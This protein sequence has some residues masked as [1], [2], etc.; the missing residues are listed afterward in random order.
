[1]SSKSAPHNYSK[2][3]YGN[4]SKRGRKGYLIVTVVLLLLATLIWTLTY[5]QY[6]GSRAQTVPTPATE[7][8]HK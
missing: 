8:V 2:S 4:A 5:T 1:M 6:I 3:P 7:P